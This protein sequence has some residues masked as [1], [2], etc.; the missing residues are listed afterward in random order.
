MKRERA[1]DSGFTLIELMISMTITSLVMA[2]AFTV[3]IQAKKL[4]DVAAETIA[5][6]RDQSNA[7]DLIERDLIQVGQ[8]LPSSKV[9]SIPNGTGVTIKRPGPGNLTLATTT[10]WPAVLPGP[11]LG[12][13]VSGGPT[14]DL[15]TMLYADTLFVTA[16]GDQPMA[17][18]AADCASMTVTAAVTLEV[19]DIIWF[20]VSS[21]NADATQ[22]VTSVSYNAGTG[23]QTVQFATGDVFGFNNRTATAGTIKQ[24]QPAPTTSAFQAQV[25]RLRMVTYYVDASRT[26]SALI[27]CLNTQCVGSSPTAGQV[28]AFGIENLQFSYDLVN[29]STDLTNIKMTA[30]DQAGT[31]VSPACNPTACST[32]QIRKVNIVVSMRSR[33]RVSQIKDF[34]HRT[35]NTQVSLRNMSFM[36]KYPA[37]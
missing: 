27:R 33:H 35:L 3:F 10:D 23:V 25:T 24:A 17:T 21:T 20:Y 18:V 30:A 2:A 16:A 36:D 29:N 31:G 1:F 34:V 14:T 22:V 8:G 6:N 11:A 4:N 26:P 12:P 19:G 13:S 28:V 37:T 32:N 15:T 9:I 7:L 5:V